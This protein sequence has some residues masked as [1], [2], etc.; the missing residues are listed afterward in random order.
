MPNL[1]KLTLK[2]LLIIILALFASTS[3]A[4]VI[5]YM[6]TGL[7]LNW[8]MYTLSS[9]W[10]VLVGVLTIDPLIKAFSDE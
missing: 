1:V 5:N 3:G 6:F 9:I 2:A 7:N 8:L 10:G 4:L